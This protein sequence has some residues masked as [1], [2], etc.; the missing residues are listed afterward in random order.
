MQQHL[1]TSPLTL[2][3]RG[4]ISTLNPLGNLRNPYGLSGL[5]GGL[6]SSSCFPSENKEP[7][8]MSG[9]SP[10]SKMS[11]QWSWL[12]LEWRVWRFG[13]LGRRGES[14]GYKNESLTKWV[15]GNEGG[16]LRNGESDLGSR[17]VA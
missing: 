8:S 4:A 14:R 3:A 1:L 12:F 16:F 13:L 5:S 11:S 7:Y 9:S 10:S 2:R 15:W 17:E 6:G